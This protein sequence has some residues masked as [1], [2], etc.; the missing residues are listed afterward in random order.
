MLSLHGVLIRGGGNPKMII[1][2]KF[3]WKPLE[4]QISNPSGEN[5]TGQYRNMY[6]PIII[7]IFSVLLW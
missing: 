2:F 4:G 1:I 7:E 5:A 6:H 3:I